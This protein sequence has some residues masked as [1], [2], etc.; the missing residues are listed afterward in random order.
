M[1]CCCHLPPA[2]MCLPQARGKRAAL[3]AAATLRSKAQEHKDAAAHHS[4]LSQAARNRWQ[5]GTEKALQLARMSQPPTRNLS[6]LAETQASTSTASSSPNA[7]IQ[8]G[9]SAF[10][11]GMPYPDT[12]RRT[13]STT[14]DDS[15]V[16]A[17][18]QIEMGALGLDKSEV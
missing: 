14:Q 17:A 11:R 13:T 1:C 3:L 2:P 4:P 9:S 6:Q 8:A 10:F 5:V 18:I 12:A 16:L 15:G 7:E